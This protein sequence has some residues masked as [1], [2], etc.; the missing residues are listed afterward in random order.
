MSYGK[1]K[2]RE[3]FSATVNGR[4]F[5]F[6]CY[7]QYC[8][9]HVR[10]LCCEGFSNTTEPKYIKSDIIGKDIWQNRPWYEFKYQKA[11]RNGINNLDEPQEVKDKLKAIIVDKTAQDEK[12][13][14]D[15]LTDQFIEN[16]NN[17]SDTFKKAVQNS[18]YM[19]QSE[20]DMES[21]NRL[22][23]VDKAFQYL[24]KI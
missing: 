24:T 23:L 9:T 13:K 4:E 14:W 5:T 8:G 6:T 2:S 3:V 7:T 19:I 15:A 11:L 17:T 10:E 18:N 12:E 16:Y 21:F 1:L 22:M 20:S